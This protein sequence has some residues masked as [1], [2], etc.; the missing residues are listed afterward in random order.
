MIDS[1]RFFC[2]F[3]ILWHTLCFTSCQLFDGMVIILGKVSFSLTFEVSIFGN[4]PEAKV[5]F[6]LN[7]DHPSSTQCGRFGSTNQVRKDKLLM[8][9]TI[10]IWLLSLSVFSSSIYIL[11]T[12]ILALIRRQRRSLRAY[13]RSIA[14]ANSIKEASS[15]M[16]RHVPALPRIK[17]RRFRNAIIMDIYEQPTG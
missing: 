13:Y 16:K 12:I 5:E 15:H 11:T 2:G 7:Y 1:R 14:K 8:A 17:R 4:Q 6:K 3:Y 9:K 10:E